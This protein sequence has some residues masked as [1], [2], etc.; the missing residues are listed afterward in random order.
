VIAGDRVL[1]ARR[2]RPAVGWEF[3]GG[4]IEPGEAPAFAVERELH[5]E[6]DVTVRAVS[7]LAKA[8]DD[9]IEL[10]LWHAML[11]AGAPEARDDHDAVAWLAADDLDTVVWLPVDR[12]LLDA[13]RTLL[14]RQRRETR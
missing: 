9:R 4:K 5:E 3:P 8:R 13:V 14:S 2:R 6:L 12:E 7:L 1:A 11:V 10:Q